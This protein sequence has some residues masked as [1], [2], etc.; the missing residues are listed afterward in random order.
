M[1]ANKKSKGPIFVI[2]G[3]DPS[4]AGIH[5][6]IETANALRVRVNS[7][8]TALTVQNTKR[9]DKIEAVNPD[10]LMQQI[11]CLREEQTPK[12]VKIGLIPS[13]EIAFV[14]SHFLK[15]LPLRTP[16]IIDPVLKSGSNVPLVKSEVEEV[17]MKELFPKATV[18]TPNLFEATKLTNR[19]NPE[20]A[21]SLLL[22]SGCKSVLITDTEPSNHSI[23]S[24]LFQQNKNQYLYSVK[25]KKGQYHGTGC[26]LATAV[27][28]E[29]CYGAPVDKAV[30]A[31][32]KF[33]TQAVNQAE[34]YG[35]SQ[36]IPNRTGIDKRRDSDA[37]ISE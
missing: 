35:L 6:D 12:A 13:E 25:R 2:G 9:V 24:V 1:I 37:T 8:V 33:A 28:C 23:K 27:A 21:A 18:I 22:R 10:T 7:L 4:G 31:A 32:I 26:T 30:A 36:S 5:A 17:L 29:L 34:H 14:V 20:T 19:N 15:T 11:T 16:I 3:H